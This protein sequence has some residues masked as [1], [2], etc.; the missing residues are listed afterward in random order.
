MK[1]SGSLASRLEHGS[2]AWKSSKLEVRTR[3]HEDRGLFALEQ[4]RKNEVL[5]VMGGAVDSHMSRCAGQR[6]QR[7]LEGASELVWSLPFLWFL[8][9]VT[10]CFYVR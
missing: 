1:D 5:T 3:N 6:L 9:Y 4:I 10:S 8:S 2:L 7:T